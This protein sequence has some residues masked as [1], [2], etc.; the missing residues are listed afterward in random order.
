MF[1]GRDSATDNDPRRVVA[2]VRFRAYETLSD[3]RTARVIDGLAHK[4]RALREDWT[5]V[6]HPTRGWLIDDIQRS[7]KRRSGERSLARPF[8]TTDVAEDTQRTVY[9]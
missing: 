6:W 7:H 9:A 3:S 8:A 4:R 2:H 5:L 1:V